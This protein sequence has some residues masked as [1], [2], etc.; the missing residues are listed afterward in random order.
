MR[1]RPLGSGK[2]LE[3]RR[4]QAVLEVVV[5]GA[6]PSSVAKKYKVEIGTIYRWCGMFR[7]DKKKGSKL[8]AYTW[9]PETNDGGPD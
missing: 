8:S 5:E 3:A 4:H 7:K 6:T 2:K 1:G 9:G